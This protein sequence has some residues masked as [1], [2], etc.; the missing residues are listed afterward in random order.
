MTGG[1]K[2]LGCSSIVAVQ[3]QFAEGFVCRNADA[4]HVQLGI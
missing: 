4:G 3:H 1:I 2:V